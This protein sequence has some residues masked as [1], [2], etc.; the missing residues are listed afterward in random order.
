MASGWKPAADMRVITKRTP[1]VEAREIVTGRARFS[2]DMQPSGCLFG[3]FLTCPHPN[4]TIRN[5]DMSDA[6]AL[7]GVDIGV[8]GDGPLTYAGVR[9]LGH[10]DDV[11]A[12]LARARVFVHPSVEEGMG[13]AVVEA[14]LA[15]VRANHC[16]MS[17]KS[18]GAR[19]RAGQL[20]LKV[21]Q[22]RRCSRKWFHTGRKW[23]LRHEIL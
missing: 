5:I 4:V 23:S 3:R 22:V 10:R 15:G 13:S 21:V 9:W 17:C 16:S 6:E 19:G 8:A 14:M 20:L 18:S 7:P 1:R 11:P 2:G 12:L